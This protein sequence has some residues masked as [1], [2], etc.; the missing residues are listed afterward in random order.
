MTQS[1]SPSV[2]A[3]VVTY[4]PDLHVL[5]ALLKA[6][7]PQ[8]VGTVVVDNGSGASIENWL[9]DT[10]PDVACIALGENYGIAKAQNVGIERAKTEDASHVVL[11]DQ[12]SLPETCM[13]E[14]L[15]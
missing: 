10:Y 9:A 15:L 5:S 3:V 6:V 14:K 1:H 2:V 12:D 11:F 7:Q 8:V 13:I 4:H